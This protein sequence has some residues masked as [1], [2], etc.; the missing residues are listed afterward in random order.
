MA[1]IGPYR[2]LVQQAYDSLASDTSA[3]EEEVRPV[4][5]PQVAQYMQ[6]EIDRIRSTL[7]VTVPEIL[8]K[9]RVVDPFTVLDALHLFACFQFMHGSANN[10]TE[11][12]VTA[13]RWLP[14]EVS[15]G[16]FHQYFFNSAGDLWP[17][18]LKVLEEGEDE[19]S[20][21]RFLDLISIF[22]NR[23]PSIHRRKRWAQMQAIEVADRLRPISTDTRGSST[24]RNIRGPSC[25]GR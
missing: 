15:N 20:V 8:A 9:R 6:T 22:P 5:T 16:G 13:C 14:L 4:L 23:Q 7:G 25:F 18:V 1:I 19:E 11:Q 10:E 24:R 17:F 21:R 3:G 2:D 12:I